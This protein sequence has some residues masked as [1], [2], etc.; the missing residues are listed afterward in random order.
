MQTDPAV[1]T[2]SSN[3]C[4]VFSH[5]FRKNFN[6]PQSND[7]DFPSQSAASARERNLHHLQ[8]PLD[9][10]PHISFHSPS[11]TRLTHCDLDLAHWLGKDSIRRVMRQNGYMI[12]NYSSELIVYPRPEPKYGDN[13]GCES[14]LL[15]PWKTCNIQRG[16]AGRSL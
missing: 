11:S 6:M 1:C 16:C 15:E 9:N 2:G 10:G 5:D 3:I 14:V 8:R 13:P 7:S 4:H 12:L